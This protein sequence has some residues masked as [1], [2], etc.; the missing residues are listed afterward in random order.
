M[1][2]KLTQEMKKYITMDQAP[3]ARA[4]IAD[5][6]ED[7]ST[8]SDYIRYAISAVYDGNSYNVEVLK[9]EAEIAKN[10]RC[11]NA[12]GEDSEN[13]DVWVEATAYANGDEF[14]IIGAYLTDIWNITGDN[15]REIASRFY[16]RRFKEERKEK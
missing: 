1:K 9:A 6:K 12:Y 13:L 7:E 10:C 14:L 15:N 4:I 3:K 11:W 8:P 5:M 16:V 2:V